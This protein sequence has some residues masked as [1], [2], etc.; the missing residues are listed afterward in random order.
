[1]RK[2]VSLCVTLILLVATSCVLSGC[3]GND[4]KK[5][6]SMNTTNSITVSVGTEEGTD[7]NVSTADTISSL[8]LCRHVY[9]GLYKKDQDGKIVLGQAKSVVVSEDKK[10]WEFE[11]RDDI[12]WDDGK[13]VT[14]SDFVYGLEFT[15]EN[16]GS[17]SGLLSNYGAKYEAVTDKK[18]IITLDES[19]VFLDTL[20]EFPSSYPKREDYFAKY[21]ELYGT[22]PEYTPCNGPYTL[23]EWKHDAQ[24][25]LSKNDKYYNKDAVSVDSIDW[26]LLSDDNAIKLL[27]DGGKLTYSQEVYSDEQKERG[28]IVSS[29]SFSLRC[30]YFNFKEDANS[31]L[32]DVRVRKALSLV[33]DRNRLAKLDNT[34]D[35]PADGFAVRGFVNDEGVDYVDYAGRWYEEGRYESDCELAR[36]L[37]KEAGYENGEGIGELRVLV[38]N[39]FISMYFQSIID[40][41]KNQ[42]GI[43][44]VVIEKSEHF[45]ADRN[46]GNFD[47]AYLNWVL[48]YKDLTNMYYAMAEL[49][50]CEIFYEG[51]EFNKAYADAC[52]VKEN[53][54]E[55]LK[56]CDDILKEDYPVSPLTY[57][58]QEY[59]LNTDYEGLIFENNVPIFTYLKNKTTQ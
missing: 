30:M 59:Y 16:G 24:L 43:T 48:D 26:K 36:T 49:G 58:R 47:I 46:D 51:K 56:K 21:G 33:V 27:Y 34:D 40:D 32:K 25:T 3:G 17:Y 44:T 57:H 18:L 50:D 38:S 35:L 42:L 6:E 54:W 37:L 31:A 19:C 45:F 22:D 39:D 15:E 4:N 7:F 28:E 29:D 1:M 13:E 9:E 12:F 52:V 41:W 5:N 2:K 23:T 11:L 8:S 14:A 53:S 10:I 55:A 20:L